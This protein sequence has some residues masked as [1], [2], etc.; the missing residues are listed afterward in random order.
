MS[1]LTTIP[2]LDPTAMKRRRNFLGLWCGKTP[3]AFGCVLAGKVLHPQ[4]KE[5]RRE[6]GLT[7]YKLHTQ[8]IE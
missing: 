1:K 8:N 6:K 4:K 5:R 7:C 3:S 2:T